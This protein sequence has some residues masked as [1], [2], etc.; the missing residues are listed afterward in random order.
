MNIRNDYLKFLELHA[1]PEYPFYYRCAYANMISIVCILFGPAFPLLYV[2]ALVGLFNFYI[3]ERLT[4]T[5]F[6]RIPP[7]F[8]ESLTQ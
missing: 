5:Y 3:M 1:G 4:L 7:K 2:F 8:N 6:Y